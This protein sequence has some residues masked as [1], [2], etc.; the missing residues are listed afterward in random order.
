VDNV[1]KTH[2]RYEKFHSSCIKGTLVRTLEQ[3]HYFVPWV[4]Y[5]SLFLTIPHCPNIKTTAMRY[6]WSSSLL[7][8]WWSVSYYK[9]QC[10]TAQSRWNSSTHLLFIIYLRSTQHLCL[11]YYTCSR[12]KVHTQKNKN[13]VLL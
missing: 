12:I 5:Y 9:C 7:R 11:L 2:Y 10:D 13:N 8:N 3:V 4:A 1:T 6:Q